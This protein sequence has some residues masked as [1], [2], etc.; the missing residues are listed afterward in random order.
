[1]NKCEKLLD[2]SKN[3][4]MSVYSGKAGRCCCG[5]AGKHY[6]N[7]KHVA[8]AGVN[9]GYKISADEVNDTMIT[10]VLN[11]LKKNAH[12]LE[13]GFDEHYFSI[14]LDNRLYIAYLR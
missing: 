8:K 4:V 9:R 12:L 6:Y 14:T 10:R 3:D 2:L 5:C 7:S 1:M 11:T 13:S